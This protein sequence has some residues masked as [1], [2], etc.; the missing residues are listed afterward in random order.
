MTFQNN[1]I[2]VTVWDSFA[3]KKEFTTMFSSLSL[4]SLPSRLAL[5]DLTVSYKDTKDHRFLIDNN[6]L[7][8]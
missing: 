3:L 7:N 6:R 1:H 5:T 8:Y 4:K 2:M